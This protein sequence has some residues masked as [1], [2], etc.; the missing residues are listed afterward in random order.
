[1]TSFPAAL[2]GGNGELRFRRV[3]RHVGVNQPKDAPLGALPQSGPGL[4]DPQHVGKLSFR[5]GGNGDSERGSLLYGPDGHGVKLVPA[6][7]VPAVHH[8][9]SRRARALL[10]PPYRGVHHTKPRREL[11]L[12]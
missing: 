1:M 12:R 3:E 7:R 5:D 6:C 4:N 11:M 8:L 10:D 2:V 9:K